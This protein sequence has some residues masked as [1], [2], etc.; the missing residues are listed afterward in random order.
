MKTMTSCR[1]IGCGLLTMAF[2]GADVT[3]PDPAGH[4]APP[5]AAATTGIAAPIAGDDADASTGQEERGR[6]SEGIQISE[7]GCMRVL[8]AFDE[9]AATQESRVQQIL[10]D[11]DY[12][13]FPAGSY[14]TSKGYDVAGARKEMDRRQADLLCHV[15]AGLRPVAALGDFKKFEAEVTTQWFSV[16][17]GELLVAQTSR[18]EGERA[19]DETLARRSALEKAIDESVKQSVLKSLAKSHKMIVHEAQFTRV[20]DEVTLLGIME[21]TQCLKGVY[22]VR[23]LWFDRAKQHAGIEIIGAPRTESFWAAYIDGMPGPDK[24]QSIETVVS[25][26]DKPKPKPA[27]AKPVT[28]PADTAKPKPA[29][30]KA[31][32]IPNTK[33]REKYPDWFKE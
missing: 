8:L 2:A 4:A 32:V 17:S 18:A 10:S 27:D 16:L 15:R 7:L 24:K 31:K 1:V 13:L 23:K 29:Q 9:T 3:K 12:R 11:Y 20:P 26:D 5:L 30:V 28:R 33:L 19:R 22:H 6:I 14:V 21:Y 25:P